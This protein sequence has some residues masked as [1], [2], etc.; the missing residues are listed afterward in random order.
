MTR[1][2]TALEIALDLGFD[3]AGIAPLRPPADAE[4]FSA[5]LA[6]G[7]HAD[8][9]WLERQRER[10]L[11]PRRVL[12]EGRSLLVVGLGHAR[13][14]VE[15]PGGGRIARY[16]AG[17]D[18]HN[19]MGKALRRLVRRLAEAGISGRTRTVVDAGPL[20]ER[21]HAA[22]AGLGFLSK[23][24]N[25]LHPRFGPWFF[26]GEVLLEAELEPTPAPPAG[27]CGTCTACLDAC[28]TGAIPAP[29]VVDANLC[30]SY[31]TIENRGRIPAA[32]EAHLG[33]W[34]FGCDVCSEVCPWGARAPDA[35]AG[36]GTRPL[37]GASLVDWLRRPAAVLAE[38][39]RG[40]PLAR[41]KPEGLARNACLVLGHHPSEEGRAALLE[42]LEADGSPLVREAAARGLARGHG[43]EPGV[44][45]RLEA[46]AARE[47]DPAAAGGMR[48]ALGG[49][50][51]S[52]VAPRGR[53]GSPVDDRG[54][55]PHRDP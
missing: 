36:W 23:A 16:A 15:L 30:L 44:R 6:A 41:A 38:D 13:P 45:A 54:H 22:E 14:A 48:V 24:A 35:S 12:P 47:P 25:L 37:A 32:I 51:P 42:R 21:S 11:D 8:M 55:A 29:G 7:R 2:T 17:R 5:W 18:Y 27:S 39:L 1:G 34:A 33:P 9:A 49:P 26:L 40:S 20:L 10:I 53:V 43:D 31:H 46:A 19:R 52:P 4:R 28:P 3:L 50:V